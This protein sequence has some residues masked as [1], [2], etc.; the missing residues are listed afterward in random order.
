MLGFLIEHLIIDLLG[1]NLKSGRIISINFFSFVFKIALFL[2]E[3]IRNFS[4][5]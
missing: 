2:A 3:F 5:L 1:N 4:I